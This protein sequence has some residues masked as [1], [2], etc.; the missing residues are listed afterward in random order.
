MRALQS[1]NA[2]SAQLL[3]QIVVPEKQNEKITAGNSKRFFKKQDQR[4]SDSEMIHPKSN[5]I[6]PDMILI[7][8]LSVHALQM[9]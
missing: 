7:Y 2:V 4:C 9:K 8:E 3:Y 6:L 5:V 1:V